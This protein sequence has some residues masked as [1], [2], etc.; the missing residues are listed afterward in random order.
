[1]SSTKPNKI[2]EDALEVDN[3]G[4]HFGRHKQWDTP[5]YSLLLWLSCL[6]LYCD[7]KVENFA[8]SGAWI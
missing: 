8:W 1:M 4:S 5:P 3:N 2:I 6:W 7:D